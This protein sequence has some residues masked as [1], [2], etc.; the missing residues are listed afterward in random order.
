MAHRSERAALLVTGTCP[1]AKRLSSVCLLPQ[2]RRLQRQAVLR[3]AARQEEEKRE[4]RRRK[5]EAEKREAERIAK[6]EARFQ[7]QQVRQGACR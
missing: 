7:R 5:K 2:A 4:E 3:E 1:R 6:R